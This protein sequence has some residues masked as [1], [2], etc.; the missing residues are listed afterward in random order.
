MAQ[1][2]ARIFV[3]GHYLFQNVD[4]SPRAKLEE[5][6]ELQGTDNVQGQ[7]YEHVFS[8]NRG[9]CVNYPSNILQRAWNSVYEQLTVCCK[10]YFVLCILWYDVMNIQIFPLRRYNPQNVLSSSIKFLMKTYR[11][12]CKVWK[13]GNITWVISS[14]APPPGK[15]LF[16]FPA[17]RCHLNYGS[18]NFRYKITEH[19]RAKITPALQARLKYV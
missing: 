3:C 11:S 1:K 14:T 19:S 10:I 5:N 18:H 2:Y 13:L 6:C 12:G 15:N 17:F 16:L 8:Q 7:I 4:S 9:C